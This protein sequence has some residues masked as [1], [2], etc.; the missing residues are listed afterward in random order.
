MPSPPTP[1]SL[2]RVA[3]VSA[4]LAQTAEEGRNIIV[5]MLFVGLVFLAVI[6][7]G[8]LNS[9]RIHRKRARRTRYR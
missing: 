3:R 7:L 9:W 8:E 2:D 6:A 5:G 1:T 4:F